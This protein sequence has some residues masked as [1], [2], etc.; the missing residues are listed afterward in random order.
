MGEMILPN[1]LYNFSL[2]EEN[3]RLLKRQK[4]NLQ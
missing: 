2:M 4:S 1:S 3:A